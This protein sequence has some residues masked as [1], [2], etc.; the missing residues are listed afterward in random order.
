MRS[1]SETSGFEPHFGEQHTPTY[2][3]S[4]QEVAIKPGQTVPVLLSVVIHQAVT[5]HLLSEDPSV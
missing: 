2:L 4:D 3:G 5:E 1:A